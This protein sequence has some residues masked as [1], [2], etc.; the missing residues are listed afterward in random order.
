MST[1]HAFRSFRL[2]LPSTS[3]VVFMKPVLLLLSSALLLAAQPAR[4][5]QAQVF[6]N[7]GDAVPGEDAV[8]VGAVFG[9]MSP[10]TTFRDGG[11]F[12]GSTLLGVDLSFWANRFLGVKVG[13]SWTEHEGLD[14]SD[15][16]SSI[17]TD[18][19][20][21]ILTVLFDGAVRYPLGS[22]GGVAM[23]PYVAVGGGWKSYDWKFYPKY[24]PDARGFDLAW[25]YAAGMEFR[26]GAEHRL[27]FRA[28]F[29][30]LRTPIDEWGEKLTHQDRVFTG[31]LLLNF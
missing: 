31:A 4:D 30:D 3:E 2:R 11:G 29:R 9:Q 21:K 28:E 24:G 20:P 7:L 18:R 19:D 12:G 14:A 26:V 15:G 10:Q 27:G 25:S 23:F 22:G 8:S 13:G 16:R 17:V 6:R 1:L 5:L